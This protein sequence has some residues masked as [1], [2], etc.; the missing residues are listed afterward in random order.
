MTSE[1]RA[2]PPFVPSKVNQSSDEIIGN[3][4]ISIAE[5]LFIIN[6]RDSN[7]IVM[8]TRQHEVGQE[9]A[10]TFSV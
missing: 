6:K 8:H 7:A 10:V 3:R 1:A 2:L 5:C 9:N 4:V